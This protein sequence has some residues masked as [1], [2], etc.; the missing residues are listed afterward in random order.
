MF[1]NIHDKNQSRWTFDLKEKFTTNLELA[2]ARNQVHTSRKPKS[3]EKEGWMR[4]PPDLSYKL[5]ITPNLMRK[6]SEKP[7]ELKKQMS[8]ASTIQD[9][10]I[11][12]R[13]RLF[14]QVMEQKKEQPKIITRFPRVGPYEA[15]L[16][17]VKSGKYKSTIYKDPTPYEYRQYEIGPRKFVTSYARDPQNLKLK[18][19]GLSQV[20]GLHPLTEKLPSRSRQKFITYKPV[21]RK[22][23]SRLILPK[24]PW[25]AKTVSFTRFKSERGTHTTF[26]ER[27]EETLSKLW[28]KEADQKQTPSKKKKEAKNTWQK[29]LNVDVS[30][31]KYSKKEQQDSS[32]NQQKGWHSWSSSIGI[33][34]GLPKPACL[35]SYIKPEPLGFLLPT[36]IAQSVKELR[37][38]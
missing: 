1:P 15:Q 24:E 7:K 2:L 36:G 25:P 21:E 8:R 20:H 16:S 32:E 17:F 30:T 5:Y 3:P 31:K 10:L 38:K 23:D 26:L 6:R 9:E 18:L 13:S 34:K 22:W 19:Q 33:G 4:K 29:S 37:C 12:I 35:P 11:S 28:Q 27:I 14:D